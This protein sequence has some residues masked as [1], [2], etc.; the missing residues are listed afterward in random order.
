MRVVVLGGTLFIGRRVVERLVSRGDE[1]LVVHRGITEP[2]GWVDCAHLHAPRAEFAAVAGEVARF[3]PA[4]VVDC[5]AL[6][7]ADVTAVLPHLPDAQLVVLSSMDVYRAY[8]RFRAR[9]VAEPVP[10]TE[11]SAVRAGRFPYRG[12]GVGEDDYDKLLVEPAYLAR[13]GTA[14]RLGFVYGEHDPQRREEFVLRRLRAGRRRIPFGTGNVLLSR[15]Y[16]DDAASAVLAALGNPAA[17]GEIFNVGE[18]LSR[19]VR[20]WATQILA[21]ASGAA[22]LVRVPDPYS[23]PTSGCPARSTSTCWP[24]RRRRP[25][26]SAGVP[27]TPTPRSAARSN[28]TSPTH[29]R[30][31]T[32]ASTPTR[33]PSPPPS[34]RP[35]R[36]GSRAF[37]HAP[38]PVVPRTAS[39][40]WPC[41][42]TSARWSRR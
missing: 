39:S 18:A 20:G 7:E 22:E 19:T 23:R 2:A 10:L 31:L 38:P 12:A 6:T 32:S 25:P 28:G 8:E 3:G 1:V 21:A 14:L 15:L 24:P 36:T 13:G 9:E 35:N 40:C 42:S 41:R 30:S 11:Q 17:A 33:P 27:A 26:S 4:A 5:A 29:R 16:V 34:A 37:D